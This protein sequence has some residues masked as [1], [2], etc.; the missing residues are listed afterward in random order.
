MTLDVNKDPPGATTPAGVQ[1]NTKHVKTEVLVEN[2]GTVVIGGIYEQNDRTDITKVPFFGDLPFV[3]CPVQEQQHVHATRPSCWCSSRRASSTSASRFADRRV[4]CCLALQ[5]DGRALPAVFVSTMPVMKRGGNIFL[6]GMMGAGKTTVGRL[7]A[8]RLKLRFVDS[9]H[10]IE[11]RCGV[12]IPVIFEIEGEAGFRAR[13]AQAIDELTRAR[14]AWC[15]PPAAARCSP[16]R[17]ARC[18]AAR[19]T[20][21]YLQRDAR[22]PVRAGAPRP[23]PAAARRRRRRWRGCASCYAR[24]RSALPRRRRHRRRDRRAER[25]GAGAR[26]CS[27]R[28]ETR[29]ESLSVALGSRAYPIHIGAGSARRA[30]SCTAPTWAAAAPPSSPTRWSRRSTS[31]R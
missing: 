5:H 22:G 4:S 3:G 1:I 25:A 24:A 23:Q 12:K 28:L 18:L 21:V 27:R 14:R 13:E 6:V 29:M 20:V 30:P 9:D 7:L 19:G 10:E 8:R 26:S 17:T 11:G 15:S 31:R 16:S 2:G